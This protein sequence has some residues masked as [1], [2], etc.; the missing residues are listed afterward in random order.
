MI[1]RGEAREIA[2]AIVLF[3]VAGVFL[4]FALVT[5]MATWSCNTREHVCPLDFEAGY[6]DFKEWTGMD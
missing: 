4:R 6:E 2:L 3:A 5:L 1:D